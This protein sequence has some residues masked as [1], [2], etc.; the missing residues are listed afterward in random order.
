[1]TPFLLRTVDELLGGKALPASILSA[2]SEL[3]LTRLHMVYGLLRASIVLLSGVCRRLSLSVT[4]WQR[5]W[6]MQRNSPGKGRDGGPVLENKFVVHLAHARN[7]FAPLTYLLSLQR[8]RLL[9]VHLESC[10]LLVVCKIPFCV[11]RKTYS[12]LR[13]K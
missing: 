8:Q 3:L 9:V 10:S 4:P 11:A 1:M 12:V 13:K 5:I 2:A 6:H 7:K